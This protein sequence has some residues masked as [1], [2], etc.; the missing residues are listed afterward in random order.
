MSATIS[1]APSLFSNKYILFVTT[2]SAVLAADVTVISSS[3][4]N[5]TSNVAASAYSPAV[6]SIPSMFAFPK[7][8][9]KLLIQTNISGSADVLSLPEAARPDFNAQP[10]G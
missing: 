10:A 5:V 1:V 8:L 4:V 9:D 2:W 7:T 3:N 6:K